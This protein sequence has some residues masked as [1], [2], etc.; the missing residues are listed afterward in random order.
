MGGHGGKHGRYPESQ[1][2]GVAN[3]RTIG[4]KIN[5]GSTE[6]I[7]IVVGEAHTERTSE[8]KIGLSDAV[9]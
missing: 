9:Y 4:G 7:H 8:V 5:K 6:S 1:S 3:R 2:V